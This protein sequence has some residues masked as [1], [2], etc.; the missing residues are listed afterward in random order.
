LRV[1]PLDSRWCDDDLKL[2]SASGL[3]GVVLPKGEDVAAIRQLRR[4]LD[5][6]TATGEPPALILVG[7]ETAKGLSSVEE[8]TQ[9]GA[10]DAVYFGAEDYITDLGGRRTAGGIE[11]LYARSR[12]ALAV[13]LGGL[14]GIDQVV[15]DYSDDDGFVS[16]AELARHLGLH[17]KLC[18]HPRQVAL[19]NRIFSPSAE[20]RQEAIEIV[21]AAEQAALSGQGVV[22]VAGRMI[23]A[24]L[25]ER[26]KR[27]LDEAGT[28]GETDL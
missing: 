24:P 16:D 6:V 12:V 28:E 15:V 13:R 14:A 25:V 7:V 2:T 4:R 26:A 11:V 17:G 20:E 19:A 1:N 18:V 3:D 9:S 23:D 5:A 8:I 21:T 22:S 27:I 10:V